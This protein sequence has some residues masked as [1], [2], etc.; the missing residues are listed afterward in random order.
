M[1]Q[2]FEIDDGRSA[3][4]EGMVKQSAWS[5]PYASSPESNLP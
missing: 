3:M 5:L 1:S 2:C 4:L